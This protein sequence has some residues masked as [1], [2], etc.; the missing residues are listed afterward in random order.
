MKEQKTKRREENGFEL[1]NRAKV[2]LIKSYA[3]GLPKTMK[4]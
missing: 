2:P 4:G 1:K 3:T